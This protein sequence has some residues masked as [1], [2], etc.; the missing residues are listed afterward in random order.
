M[1]GIRSTL[2]ALA[3]WCLFVGLIDLLFGIPDFGLIGNVGFGF[4]LGL[5]WSVWKLLW[6]GWVGE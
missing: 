6:E 2:L 5:C 1:N 4:G 3:G